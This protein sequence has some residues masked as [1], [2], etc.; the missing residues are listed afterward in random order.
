M[1]KTKFD[2]KRINVSAYWRK[3]SLVRA[4]TRSYPSITVK[5]SKPSLVS[6][7]FGIIS[8]PFKFAIDIIV[9]IAITILNILIFILTFIPN[10]LIKL[11]SK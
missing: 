8:L 1:T 5:Q 6:K 4:H 2:K 10:L 11:F 7:L 9:I 3:G